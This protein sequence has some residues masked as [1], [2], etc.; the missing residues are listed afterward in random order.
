MRQWNELG[1]WSLLS[2]DN[3]V[4]LLGTAS[5]FGNPSPFGRTMSLVCS[6][7]ENGDLTGYLQRVESSLTLPRCFELVSDSMLLNFV[8][9]YNLLSAASR[10][11]VR[12]II[13]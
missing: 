10:R 12:I 6:W 8:V 3:V 4:P 2:H 5:G 7:M 9:A 1:I 11:G 13:Q